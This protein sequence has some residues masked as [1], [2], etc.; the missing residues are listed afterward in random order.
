MSLVT[1][2]FV[3]GFGLCAATQLPPVALSIA[4]G[5]SYLGHIYRGENLILVAASIAGAWLWTAWHKRNV[6]LKPVGIHELVLLFA[7]VWLDWPFLVCICAAWLG[8]SKTFTYMT[9][10]SYAATVWILPDPLELK[11]LVPFVFTL[12]DTLYCPTPDDK[13]PVQ[14][15]VEEDHSE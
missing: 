9:W 12:A 1:P 14:D 13:P 5:V 15:T 2:Y 3:L 7:S 6:P 10:C 11:L 8:E 4:I